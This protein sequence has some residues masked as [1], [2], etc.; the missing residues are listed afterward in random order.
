MYSFLLLL[1]CF[2]TSSFNKYKDTLN[3]VDCFLQFMMYC[4]CETKLLIFF[5]I[6]K[7]KHLCT[8]LSNNMRWKSFTEFSK[9]MQMMNIQNRYVNNQQTK[10]RQLKFSRDHL[11]FAKHFMKKYFNLFFYFWKIWVKTVFPELGLQSSI[12]I[13]FY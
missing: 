13:S 10:R 6:L 12:A 8:N 3:R 11:V 2:I 5:N 1:T 7:S 4:D 9:C